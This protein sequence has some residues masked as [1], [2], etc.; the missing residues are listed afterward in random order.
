MR[1][2]TKKITSFLLAGVMTLSLAACGNDTKESNEDKYTYVPEYISLPS[3]ENSNNNVLCV[4]GTNLIYNRYEWD[5]DT[6]ESSFKLLRLDFSQENPTPEELPISW[7]EGQDMMQ[8]TC[9]GEGNYYA[10]IRQYEMTSEGIP[11]YNKRSLALEK[12]QSD[13]EVV[14]SVD[15]SS[16]M[17]DSEYSYIQY[18][19]L[20]KDGNIY[21]S[22][23][24]H[25]VWIFDKEGQFLFDINADNWIQGLGR[26][27]DGDVYIMQWGN[28]DVELRKIDVATKALGTSLTGL[29]GNMNYN[30]FKPGLEKDIMVL[31]NNSLY[32]Y[33]INTQTYETI[34]NY[35]DC[36]IN[37]NNIQM[38]SSLEDGRIFL[39]YRDYY[40]NTSDIML[41]TKTLSTNME[42][43]KI[44]T[45]G[46]M[47]VE[48]GVQSAIIAFNKS[49]P[50]Y[51]IKVKDYAE[52]IDRSSENGYQ[53]AITQ[54]N[55]D[56][57]I[58]NAP[59][60][61]SLSNVRIKQLAAKGVLEDIMPYLENSSILEKDNLLESVLTA[62][63]YSDVLC[64]IPTTFSISTL[65]SSVS[66]VGDGDSWTLDELMAAANAMPEGSQIIQYANQLSIL[67]YCMTFNQDAFIDWE[68]GKCNF[69]GEEFIKVLEFANQF[70]AGYNYSEDMPEMPDLI[71]EGKLLLADQYVSSVSDYQIIHTIFGEPINCIGYPTSTGSGSALQGSG[72][73]GITSKS[74][75]KDGAWQFIE[76][77]ISGSTSNPRYSWGFSV[78][79]DKLEEQFE[80]EMKP[81]YEYDEKGEILLD[82]EGNKVERS[83]GGWSFGNGDSY[84]IYASTQEE[85]DAVRE[86][87][88]KTTT[89]WAYENDIL[90][91]M[92]EEAEPYFQGQKTAQ[93]VANI[94]QSRIQVYVNE[95]S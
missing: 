18:M 78:M 26:A 93:E 59:D 48:D 86:L 42:E 20:D 27:K 73:I 63:T 38:V 31:G 95:N 74:K 17:S 82:N 54:L 24:Q 3:D 67:N 5:P 46:C 10:A 32:D 13:G 15:L 70:P 92:Q 12:Y 69:T 79:K 66:L 21:V 45:Y 61:I 41:L 44:I 1:K 53:D 68:T 7:E 28:T 25:S 58:G 80:E 52:S 40:A 84:E 65:M 19:D 85:V 35:L 14:F 91:I 47:Y 43:K 34:L 37:G 81:E 6:Y 72:A 55:N 23:S 60:L 94:I 77:Y 36:D 76:S 62:Y 39:Y 71:K 57:L 87:I 56:I 29:P 22:D 9:D 88:N 33:D 11:D 49:N 90:T 50:E 16:H 75:V 89:V 64:G 4:V 83:Q 8:M 51:R 30:G 2:K